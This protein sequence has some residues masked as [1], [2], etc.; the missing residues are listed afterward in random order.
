LS[1]FPQSVIGINVSLAVLSHKTLPFDYNRLFFGN[2]FNNLNLDSMKKFFTLTFLFLTSWALHAQLS[3]LMQENFEGGALPTGWTQTTLSTDTGWKFGTTTAL[4]SQY[5]GIENNGSKIAATNDDKCNCNKSKDYLILPAIDLSGQ[6][7]VWMKF[8]LYFWDATYGGA[9]EDAT[10][11]ASLD[12]GATW[13]IMATLKGADTWQKDYAVDLSSLAGNNNVLLAFHYNDGGG[14]LF[15]CAIDNVTVFVPYNRDVK[16]A[17]ATAPRY[18]VFGNTVEISGKVINN[19]GNQ[20][21]SF[22][23]SWT[24]GVNVHT[25][26]I[27][28][29]DVAPFETYAFTHSTEFMVAQAVTYNLDV[30]VDNPNGDTDED[31]GNNAGNTKVYGVLYAP[32]RKMVAEEA[33]GTWCGWCPRGTDWMEYMA[34]NYEDD[35]I[36][37]AVHNGDPMVVAAYDQ[38]VRAF[39]DFPGFPSVIIDRASIIDPNELEE[40]LEDHLKR[41]GPAIP[42]I[43]AKLDV[44]ARTLTV[45]GSAEF[46]GKLDDVDI[47][48]NLVLTEDDVQ[49]TAATYAQVNYYSFQSQNL[50]D[51]IPGY[52]LDWQTEPTPVPAAKMYYDHVARYLHSGWAGAAGSAPANINVGDIATV[53]YSNTNFTATWNPFKMHA[54]VIV[55]DNVTG[56]IL[57]GEATKVEVICPADLGLTWT[58]TNATG[59]NSDG[60]VTVTVPSQTIGY[61]PYTFSWNTGATTPNLQ[62]VPAGD[63]TLVVSDKIGCKQTLE[64]KVDATT[65]VQDIEQLSRFSLSPNP[66]KSV[67]VLDVRFTEAVDMKVEITNAPGQVLFTKKVENTTGGQH[68]FDLG[69]FA[70]GMYLVKVSVGNQM[71][72]E[73]LLLSK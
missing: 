1:H 54:I 49:G 52:G 30:T 57:N 37:I 18:A 55:T 19:S 29:I 66:A 44:A 5:W 6:T 15:G 61:S 20:L 2:L 24:D 63:Y 4:Q 72:V 27:S 56:E 3:I 26:N 21:T 71:H 65:N 14:W 40:V 60:A 16:L 10:V 13:Q 35:F 8:D 46:N 36:G 25:D 41:V 39:P 59:A 58:V 50:P 73:R 48:L 62:G 34:V 68:T 28:G 17:S 38:G 23:L 32:K 12:G 11:E 67:S 7:S 47:R 22:D 43:E 69:N 64:I 70:E 42:S 51:P 9:P 45:D 33:T 31:M 53:Q